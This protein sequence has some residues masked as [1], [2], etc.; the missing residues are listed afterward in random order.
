[1]TTRPEMAFNLAEEVAMVTGAGS[2]MAGRLGLMFCSFLSGDT[3][4]S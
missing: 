2:R 4:S 3:D 1:M